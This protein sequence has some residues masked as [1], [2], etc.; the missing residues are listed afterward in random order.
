[1]TGKLL[2]LDRA[3]EPTL[4]A[5]AGAARCARRGPRSGRRSIRP[6]AASGPS[7]PSSASCCA[8]AR[9]SRSSW[10]SRT[11]TGST[12]RPRRCSTA[13]S[14]ACRRPGSCCSS[15]TGRST[16][17]AG[18]S[19]TYYT[20]APARRPRRRRAPS[21]LLGALLGHDAG[22]RAAQ[23][24][25]D[26]ADRGQPVL[27]RG[28]RADAGRDAARSRASAAPI[29]WPGRSPTIQ[30]PGH[31]AGDP[32]R[33]HRPA[34]ARGQ[35]APPDGVGHR[36]GRA[37]SRCSQAI[38]ELRRGRRCAAGSP[39]SRPPSSSTRRGLFPDLE[40]TFKH[41][42]THEVAY[43]EP[44]PGAAPRACTPGSSR[45]SSAAI[46]TGSAEHVERLA[47][48]AFRGEVWEKAVALPAPGR[49]QG[50]GALGQPRGR[51]VL[52]AG[53]RGPAAPARSVRDAGAG[54]RPSASS[55]ANALLPLGRFARASEVLRDA[56][57]ACER[58]G[59]QRR[60]GRIWAVRWAI[61]CG[62]AGRPG[63]S[64]PSRE[65]ARAACRGRSEI[66]YAQISANTNLGLAP[67]RWEITGG[68]GMP[69]GE[70]AADPVRPVP[71]A[72]RARPLLPSVERAG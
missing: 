1:M 30:V 49:G 43:G 21:E 34:A 5:L 71:R 28:E 27:P 47:H 65:R 25:P 55:S 24:R 16:S 10:S 11:S 12:P 37:R 23:A 2:T 69:R 26:R 70:S 61:S 66:W 9:C 54:H 50:P 38:A 60:L 8:R 4:P 45:P 13:W 51:H 58:L 44:A 3:L 33:A 6:S 35:A 20:P 39:A 57:S 14:R 17:T 42:L 31:G 29:D 67:S 56:E 68:P 52:R 7:T 63:G 15:T 19:K 59:D 64:R 48:H 46:P 72:L 36:Q 22:A 62:V 32:G 18:A 40:Y 53:A 41:A